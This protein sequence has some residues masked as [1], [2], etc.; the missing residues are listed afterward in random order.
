VKASVWN[1]AG[2]GTDEMNVVIMTVAVPLIVP[3]LLVVIVVEL[4][5]TANTVE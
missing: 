1:V 5:R 2:G 4:R 3:V